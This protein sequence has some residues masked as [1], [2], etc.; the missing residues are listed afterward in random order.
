[1]HHFEAYIFCFAFLCILSFHLQPDRSFE[2]LKIEKCFCSVLICH[3]E[4]FQNFNEPCYISFSLIYIYM[5]KKAT[6][7]L[8]N[9]QLPFTSYEKLKISHIN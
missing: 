2:L 6:A 5:F 9:R 1:M 8:K 3:Y 4:N 7:I